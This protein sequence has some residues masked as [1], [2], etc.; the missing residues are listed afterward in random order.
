M[1]LKYLPAIIDFMGLSDE[2]SSN[3]TVLEIV[4]PA[5]IVLYIPPPCATSP[6][7]LHGNT[8]YFNLCY[9]IENVAFC[10]GVG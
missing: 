3:S 1:G 2:D 6:D 7:T 9:V 10:S 4:F 8:S 5:S